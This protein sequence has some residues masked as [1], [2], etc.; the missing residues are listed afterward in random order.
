[1]DALPHT[2]ERRR[3]VS[4]SDPME[5]ARAARGR[6]G[7]DV[8]R[9]MIAGLIPAPPIV[10]LMGIRLVS[11]EPGIVRMALTAAEYL[12]NPLGTVH[13]GAIATLLDSVMGCAVHSTLGAGQGYTTLEIK[14]NYV[15]A[16]TEA[17]GEV[18]GEGRVVHAG[19][20]SAVADAKLTDAAGRLYATASTTCL[21]FDVPPAEART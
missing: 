5:A 9:D 18:E 17:V 16:L 11:A 6:P 1:M 10:E 19:R 4:W 13:G 3:V 8:L 12:Y 15:R 21:V 7:L 2:N 20:R 14:V